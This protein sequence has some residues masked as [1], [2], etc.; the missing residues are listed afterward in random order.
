MTQKYTP[1][2]DKKWSKMA[3]MDILGIFEKNF[4]KSKVEV[5]FG[6][7]TGGIHFSIVE[8]NS[9]SNGIGLVF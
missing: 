8:F 9:L 1:K 3:K 5:Q 6:A 2:N 4:P 7:I